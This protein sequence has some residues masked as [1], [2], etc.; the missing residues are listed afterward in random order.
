M[1]LK[2]IIE[3]LKTPL[4]EEQKADWQNILSE[5]LEE[6]DAAAEGPLDEWG[7]TVAQQAEDAENPCRCRRPIQSERNRTN[8]C[9]DC[10]FWLDEAAM[11]LIFQIHAQEQPCER[12]DH[13]SRVECRDW[14][15][16]DEAYWEP[17][18]WQTCKDCKCYVLGLSK[19]Q[20]TCEDFIWNETHCDE[21]G[22]LFPHVKEEGQHCMCM[23][24]QDDL[25][26]MDLIIR[27]GF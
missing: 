25:N 5:R 14:C 1:E 11:K 24:D 15:R 8:C 6:I 2:S 20:K 21:C 22:K 13:C 3:K 7:R 18:T 12:C 27:R 19:H 4:T 26:K 17:R 9:A 16:N 23:Y 10:G